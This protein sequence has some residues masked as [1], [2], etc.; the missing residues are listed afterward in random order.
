MKSLFISLDIVEYLNLDLCYLLVLKVPKTSL[1]PF[2]TIIMLH[3]KA[4]LSNKKH[5]K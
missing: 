3:K 4:L 2:V 5:L 1:D